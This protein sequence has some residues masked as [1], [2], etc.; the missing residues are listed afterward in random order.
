MAP[1]NLR[2]LVNFVVPRKPSSDAWPTVCQGLPTSILNLLVEIS[3]GSLAPIS[4]NPLLFLLRTIFARSAH[5]FNDDTI[6]IGQWTLRSMTMLHH[7]NSL[8]I[9]STEDPSDRT[10]LRVDKLVSRRRN[11]LAKP[12]LLERVAAHA[13]LKKGGPLSLV[14]RE[15]ARRAVATAATAVTAIIISNF[16]RVHNRVELGGGG[17]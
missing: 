6:L 15:R 12:A 8:Q 7:I 10:R 5:T 13:S 1:L 3:L 9:P 2:I 14:T 17:R 16:G 4:L 11:E